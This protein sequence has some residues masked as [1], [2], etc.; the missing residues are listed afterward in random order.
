LNFST[1]R[2]SCCICSGRNNERD[3]NERDNNQR[4]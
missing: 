3:S 1:T 2:N 4:D